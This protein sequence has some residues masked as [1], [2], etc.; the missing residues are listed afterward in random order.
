MEY[1]KCDVNSGLPERRQMI[2]EV[3][4]KRLQSCAH[5]VETWQQILSVRTLVL[6]PKQDT[7]TWLHF[8]RLAS[9]LFLSFFQFRRS[10]LNILSLS[11]INQL[12]SVA[13][14]TQAK[15]C[16][17]EEKFK[18]AQKI[19]SILSS[20]LPLP[21]T[22]QKE[23]PTTLKPTSLS[24]ILPFTS[25][26]ITLQHIKQLWAEGQRQTAFETL[27]KFVTTL[28][29]PPTT[30]PI[31]TTSTRIDSPTSTPLPSAVPTPLLARCWSVIFLFSLLFFLWLRDVEI[32]VCGQVKIG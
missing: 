8:V 31:T 10:C 29:T 13:L 7:E 6:H 11:S 4:S 2:R 24:S 21:G 32:V 14:F 27:K 19:F 20:E 30:Q 23:T 9:S 16:R 3:W 1:L 18:Q 26:H 5:R 12:V 25:P 15:I 22:S 28:P 17:K